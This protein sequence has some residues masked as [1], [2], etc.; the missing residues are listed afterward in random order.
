MTVLKVCY[1]NIITAKLH[2]ALQAFKISP[3][4]VYCFLMSLQLLVIN[5]CHKALSDHNCG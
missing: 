5:E 2:V 1:Q 4:F 3:A